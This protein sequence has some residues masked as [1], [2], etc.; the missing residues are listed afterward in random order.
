[1]NDTMNKRMKFDHSFGRVMQ[2]LYTKNNNREYLFFSGVLLLFFLIGT[3]FLHP[4][5]GVFQ[6]FQHQQKVNQL[7]SDMKKP[8][9]QMREYWQF[10]EFYSPGNFTFDPQVVSLAGA[11]QFSTIPSPTATLL[12]FHSPL[13][14]STDSIIDTATSGVYAQLQI[15]D[16]KNQHIIIKSRDTVA[17]QSP[18]KKFHLVFIK[19]TSEMKQT[20]GLFDYGANEDKILKSK[21]WLNQTT[22]SE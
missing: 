17:Y 20:L 19:S 14:Y 16:E 18:D 3:L 13:I 9:F 21:L 2:K 8:D 4:T 11:L 5:L 10:R 12:T 6:E 22:I 7:L 15:P 1:M